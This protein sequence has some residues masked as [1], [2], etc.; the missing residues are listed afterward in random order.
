MSYSSSIS[1]LSF[2]LLLLLLSTPHLGITFSLRLSRTALFRSPGLL[3]HSSL[4][5]LPGVVSVQYS[6]GKVDLDWAMIFLHT[7][8]LRVFFRSFPFCVVPPSSFVLPF[9][10]FSQT[11]SVGSCSSSS[12]AFSSVPYSALS[13]R[14]DTGQEEREEEMDKYPR[15]AAAKSN[16]NVTRLVL[17]SCVSECLFSL[18]LSLCSFFLG[19]SWLCIVFWHLWDRSFLFCYV[20]REKTLQLCVVSWQWRWGMIISSLSF[21]SSR[22]FLWFRFHFFLCDSLWTRVSDEGG[23][24]LFHPW[25]VF[26]FYSPGVAVDN[27]LHSRLRWHLED[28]D[29]KP[30]PAPDRISPRPNDDYDTIGGDTYPPPQLL[31]LA[32]FLLQF[33]VLLLQYPLLL[34]LSLFFSLLCCCCSCLLLL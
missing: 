26:V 14:V 27:H 20:A 4:Q 17:D 12:F 32:L 7:R 29:R 33:R 28:S 3:L 21:W 22:I 10:C 6:L 11:S 15:A 2:C 19:S 34:L 16:S 8:E 5:L 13:S 24:I 30:P 31:S 1:L 25:L 18:R 23:R 9:L